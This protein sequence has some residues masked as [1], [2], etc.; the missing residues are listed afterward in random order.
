MCFWA[1]LFMYLSVCRPASLFLFHFS[2][3]V[4]IP[5]T[6]SPPLVFPIRCALEQKHE[7]FIVGKFQRPTANCREN[8]GAV[9][10]DAGKRL[11]HRVRADPEDHWQASQS[12]RERGREGIAENGD[13]YINKSHSG[14]LVCR[15]AC[16]K[17]LYM[18]RGLRAKVAYFRCM[19]MP[20]I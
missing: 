8:T 7:A 9:T 5:S 2:D 4:L 19:V 6:V 18:S 11:S 15:E 16:K 10:A 1:S 17:V 12:K 3:F 20:S 14:T 13:E